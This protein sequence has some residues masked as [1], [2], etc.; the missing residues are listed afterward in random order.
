MTSG[1]TLTS[2]TALANASA[3]S[4]VVFFPSAILPNVSYRAHGIGFFIGIVAALT[5]YLFKKKE[6][7]MAEVWEDEEDYELE[8]L[9]YEK[10]AKEVGEEVEEVK[11]DITYH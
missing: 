8:D 2:A 5:F 6:I 9:Y 10:T 1:F 7:L 4:L 11:D 3:V